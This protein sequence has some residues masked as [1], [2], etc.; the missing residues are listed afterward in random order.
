MRS[1][2]VA[3]RVPDRQGLYFILVPSTRV[4]LRLHV[5]SHGALTSSIARFYGMDIAGWGSLP[6]RTGCFV[7]K[8][9]FFAF[10]TI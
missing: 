6:S 7:A 1:F 2:L 4:Q 9:G 3:P 8:E 5:G 10:Y